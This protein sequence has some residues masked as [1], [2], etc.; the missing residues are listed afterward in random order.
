MTE[1]GMMRDARRSPA[2]GMAAGSG[3]GTPATLRELVE[4]LD[5]ARGH[6]VA[7][8]VK[9][10]E[11]YRSLTFREVRE[12]ARAVGNALAELGIGPGDRV[13]LLAENRVEWPIA[14]LAVASIGAT[15]VSL[16]IFLTAREAARVL[17]LTTPRRVFA[18]ERFIDRLAEAWPSAASDAPDGPIIAFD[19][20]GRPDGR[21]TYA[22]LCE[23]GRALFAA[24]TDHY[25]A[26]EVD[27]EDDA[28]IIC[29]STTRGVVMSHRALMANLEGFRPLMGGDAS[30]ERRWLGQL[31]FH[32]AWPTTVGLLYPL[33]TSS[34]VTVLATSQMDAIL[35]AVGERRIDY[36]MLVPALVDRLYLAIH[37]EARRDGLFEGLELAASAGPA[38]SFEA[39]LADGDP[40][41]VALNTGA[42]S[43]KGR[44]SLVQPGRLFGGVEQRE[45]DR[46]GFGQDQ[47]AQRRIGNRADGRGCNSQDQH[48]QGEQDVQPRQ[49]PVQLWR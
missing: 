34:R 43:F 17:A 22:D 14:Y 44:Y 13:G 9:D 18:S 41:R 3:D 25:A 6:L 23:R 30:M 1:E 2:A 42:R 10:G 15:V 5:G 35:D 19:G 24:G 16:D 7:Y 48:D 8:E 26:L 29:L 46:L 12:Q 40:D 37:A 39:A 31:P 28:A 4:G 33:F 27:P 21:H 47:V 32:H 49:D 38:E 11:T 20:R 45:G 36:L